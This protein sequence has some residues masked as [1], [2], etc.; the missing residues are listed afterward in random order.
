M[1][2]MGIIIM[3]MQ[4]CSEELSDDRVI[5]GLVISDTE[6][7]QGSLISVSLNVTSIFFL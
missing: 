5:W 2:R 7:R 3:M 6:G 4:S 1:C